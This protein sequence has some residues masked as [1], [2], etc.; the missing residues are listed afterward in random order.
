MKYYQPSLLRTLLLAIIGVVASF[1]VLPAHAISKDSTNSPL[2][3]S[4]Q[5]KTRYLSALPATTSTTANNRLSFTSGYGRSGDIICPT[6]IIDGR[7][8]SNFVLTGM[9]E[10]YAAGTPPATSASNR[11]AFVSGNFRYE[12]I[13]SSGNSI[14]GMCT[15]YKYVKTYYKLDEIRI[16]CGSINKLPYYQ[17]DMNNPSSKSINIPYI[18]GNTGI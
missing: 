11:R 8:S 18:G 4:P 16:T 5:V 9:T 12:P 15:G 6:G 7:S 3:P 10:V 2:P 13:C 1:T 14:T 17:F